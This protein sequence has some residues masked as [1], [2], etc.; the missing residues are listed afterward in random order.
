MSSAA[1]TKVELTTRLGAGAASGVG[2][3][4]PHDSASLHVSGAAHYVDD[5]PAPA[6]CLHAAPIYARIACG[7]VSSMDLAAVER[8][9]GVR[10]VLSHHDIPGVNQ[11]GPV[12][13][14]EPLL[15]PGDVHYHGQLLALVVADSL[16]QARLAAERAQLSYQQQ[17]PLLDVEQAYAQDS[18]LGPDLC[19]S[20]GDP[21]AELKRCP[22]RLRRRY[23]I[24]GQEHFYLEGQVALATPEE[25][26][27]LQIFSSTQYPSEVQSVAAQVLGVQANQIRV[28]VRRMGGGFGGKETQATAVAC[29]AALAA[30]R[31]GRAVKLR[32]DRDED[33]RITGKR[34]PFVHKCEFGFDERGKL[35][36]LNALLLGNGGWSNDLTNPV[37]D[38][39]MLHADN[40]YYIPHMRV[41]GARV[42]TNICSNTA[43]RGF[44]GPQGVYLIEQV[45][46][47][48]ARHLRLDAAA[49]RRRNLYGSG[50]RGL[51]H[52]GQRVAGGWLAPM[53]T[54]LYREGD[55]A[56]LRRQV[57]AFNSKQSLFKQGLALTP[58]KFGISFTLTKHN[59]AG[60]LL[61]IYPDA[62]VQLNHG[63]TEM[64]QGLFIKV[65]QVVAQELGLS[66]D[67][68]RPMATSTDKVAN[69]SATAASSGSDLN[70]MAALEAAR[71]L[72][73][74]LSACARAH[75]GLAAPT[76]A[77]FQSGQ[78]FLGDKQISFAQLVQLA[79]DARVNL[80]AYGYY[81]TPEINWDR[82]RRQGQPFYYFACGMALSRV[83]I[84]TSTGEYKLLSSDILHD[85][86]NSLNPAV[87]VGQI[88]GAF[89]Q[90][91]GW[92]TCEQL[93]WNSSGELATHCPSTYKI[94]TARDR[95]LQLRT[96]LFDKPNRKPTVYRSKAVG[97]PPL[98]L[99]F[100]V[101]MAIKDAIGAARPDAT[102]IDLEAPATPEN[103]L[104]A[105]R[106]S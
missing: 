96:R 87:D 100:S 44:G 71:T 24:G 25:N 59:K 4:Q 77:R 74:R 43:F 83:I 84:D 95:P 39:A 53:F 80:S 18:L 27:E 10:L 2:N 3:P 67:A 49:V 85:V 1:P 40:A 11:V 28:T 60:A 82:S 13:P 61:H 63:G 21:A 103:I 81:Q 38:R 31:S 97:E 65:A 98:M 50:A 48:I 73:Q 9:P 56:R 90:G 33:M 52:Y 102:A 106:T 99:A 64:G 6:N 51:T 42:R 91:V 92:L 93:H 72:K 26:E 55:Y 78:V 19:F 30:R 104:R 69:T 5:L 34:H 35:L 75:F 22:H 36:A 8:S 62:S 68:I 47:D 14:D 46:D 89:I 76:R 7:R 29:L 88:E 32:L 12:V 70:G 23:V 37:V 17:A 16:E 58:V 86:G 94:P 54:R 66:L 57:R 101:L 41:V 79:L 45:M 20:R 15:S 105:L